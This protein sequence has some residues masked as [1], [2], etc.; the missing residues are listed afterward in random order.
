VIKGLRWTLD[1]AILGASAI[2]GAAAGLSTLY[3]GKTFGTD[4][5]YWTAILVGAS[6]QVLSKAVLD[7]VTQMRAQD[8]EPV[9]AASPAPATATAKG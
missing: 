3:F 9:E 6:S 1:L 2:I 4:S 8:T 5:D 7:A